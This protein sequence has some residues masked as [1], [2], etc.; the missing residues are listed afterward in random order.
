MGAI[1]REGLEFEV[2][3]QT[4]P[5]KGKIDDAIK[6]I[7]RRCFRVPTCGNDAIDVQ[8]DGKKLKVLNIS[9][10]GIGV[11]LDASEAWPKEGSIKNLTMKIEDQDWHIRAKVAHISPYESGD[12]ICGF[13]FIDLTPESEQALNELF[14]RV[15]NSWSESR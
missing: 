8:V 6:K 7:L 1:E 11:L 9:T 12:Y 5:T 15:M 3:V 2:G 10:G 13:Q 14:L 4:S